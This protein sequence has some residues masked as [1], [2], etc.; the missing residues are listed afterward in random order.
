[1]LLRTVSDCSDRCMFRGGV[2][3]AGVYRYEPLL[4]ALYRVVKASKYSRVCF[5]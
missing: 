2:S 3:G 4:E 1:M 5:A